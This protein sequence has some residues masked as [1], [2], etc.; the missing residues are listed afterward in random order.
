MERNIET[1]IRECPSCGE[2]ARF[3]FVGMQ[4]FPHKNIQFKMYN[5]SECKTTLS[6]KYLERK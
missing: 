3:I 2:I 4:Y 1:T 5:C 6:D